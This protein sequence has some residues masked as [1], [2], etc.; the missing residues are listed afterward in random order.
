MARVTLVLDQAALHQVGMDLAKRLVTGVTRGTLNRSAALCPVDTGL[1][2]ASGMMRIGGFGSQ[3]V[4]EVEYTADYSLAV[5]NGTR[6]HVILP[7]R[8]QYLRFQVGGRTVYARRVN[9]PGTRPRPFLAT[10]LTEVAGRE[11]FAVSIG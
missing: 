3:V 5:H 11:G 1:M 2:R 9:H 7:R 8:G 10:A 6:P 4:G